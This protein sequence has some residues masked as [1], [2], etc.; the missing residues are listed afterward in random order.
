MCRTIAGYGPLTLLLWAHAFTAIGDA[1]L[2]HALATDLALCTAQVIG[3]AALAA[4]ATVYCPLAIT[5]AKWP[6]PRLTTHEARAAV[7]GCLTMLAAMPA[8]ELLGGRSR[9]TICKHTTSA[10]IPETGGNFRRGRFART[11]GPNPVHVH[12]EEIPIARDW[13]GACVRPTAALR[14]GART[15]AA[16]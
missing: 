5:H 13:R 2:P 16:S 7:T 9:P 12:R 8:I 6:G 15:R 11:A 3:R 4:A 10:K 1:D 14:G